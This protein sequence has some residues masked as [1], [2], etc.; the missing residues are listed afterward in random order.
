MSNGLFNSDSIQ[1]NP[2]ARQQARKE[3]TDVLLVDTAGRL[4]NKNE[5]M[6][7]LQKITRVMKKFDKN[8]PHSC[9]LVLDATVGQNAHSQVEIFSKMVNV[10]GLVLTKLDGSAKGGVL[11]ALAKKFGIPVHAIGVGEHTSDLRPFKAT[12]FAHSL[13]DLET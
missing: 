2:P 12:E 1:V 10:T 8:A 13:L 6:E 9:L 5:L 11:V 3:G 7:E 4:Q